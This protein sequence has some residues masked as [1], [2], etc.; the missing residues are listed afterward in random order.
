MG[1]AM[2][3]WLGI[4]DFFVAAK[5]VNFG[6]VIFGGLVGGL[7]QP[8]V[9][10]LRP[11]AENPPTSSYWQSPLLGVAA[12]GI[13]IYVLADSNTKE[14]LRIL[15]FA[16]LCGLAFPA[17]LT[18]AVD[19]ISRRTREVTR[20]VAA[21]AQQAKADGIE[22]TAKAAQALRTVLVQNPPA[23]I[24]PAAQEVIETAAQKAVSSIAETPVTTIALQRQLIDELK[25][26]GTVAKNAGWTG[27]AQE[28]A[29]QL[30]KMSETMKDGSLK[31]SAERGVERLTTP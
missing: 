25:E 14:P 1:V 8:V 11:N 20:E 4:D 26:V 12:A 16:L 13:S 28:A 23:S 15:F 29:D 5:A 24:T 22:E 9:A 6:V 18:T 19:N 27:T 17:V 21:I 10:R 2:S 30:K 31:A 7:L 3:G